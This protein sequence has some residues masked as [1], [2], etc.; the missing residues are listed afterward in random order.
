MSTN[1]V[2]GAKKQN[3]DV[4][5]TGCWAEH[6]D[7]SM[8]FVDGVEAGTVVYSLFDRDQDDPVEYRDA[9]DEKG[10]KDQFSWKK[11]DKDK[12]TWHDK[13]P[14][15]WDKIMKTFPAGVKPVSAEAEMSAAK[16]IARSLKIRAGKVRDHHDEEPSWQK[17]AIEMMNAITRAI[18]SVGK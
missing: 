4:L 13:T 1:D 12:W 2:P 9:M 5:A 15:P 18:K 10:F 16:R 17:P 7:G 8:I 11:G 14:F 6:K 3:N